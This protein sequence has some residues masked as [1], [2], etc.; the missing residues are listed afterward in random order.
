M[1]PLTHRPRRIARSYGVFANETWQLKGYG[2]A[3]SES[4]LPSTV[5]D[6]FAEAAIVLKEPRLPVHAAGTAWSDLECYGLGFF[7]LHR[8]READFL[9]VDVWTGENMLRHV[10]QVRSQLQRE[11]WTPIANSQ[12]S[13]CVWELEIQRHEAQA[14]NRHVYRND[15]QPPDAVAYL[16]DWF[17]EPGKSKSF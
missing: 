15:A 9:L 7:I 5:E 17:V 13:V 2:I 16:N 4:E 3:L 14:W 6:E 11:C 12:L 10:V 8:G 1:K